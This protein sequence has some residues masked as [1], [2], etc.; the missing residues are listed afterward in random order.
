MIRPATVALLLAAAGCHRS[1]DAASAPPT[2]RTDAAI[3]PASA[4]LPPAPAPVVVVTKA[5][6]PPVHLGVRATARRVKIFWGKKLLGA[7]PFALERP[8]DSGPIDLLLRA[9]GYFPVHTRLYTHKN[10]AITVSMT[11]LAD[12]MTLFGAKKE[13][14]PPA[15]ATPPPAIETQ[16][17]SAPKP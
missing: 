10:D 17:V 9:E 1:T 2:P 4:A 16:P 7:T 11:K 15:T 5:P 12:R 6:L 13:P 8:R 3:A 14:A